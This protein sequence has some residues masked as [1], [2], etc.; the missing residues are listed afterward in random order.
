L[1]ERLDPLPT[2]VEADPD[3]E[4][5]LPSAWRTYRRALETTP[6]WATHRLV[7]QDD[8]AP[9][10]SFPAVLELAVAAR[11]DRI[12]VLCVC[13]R[14]QEMARQL[15]RASGRGD[16]WALLTGLR[17]LPTIAVVWPV[18]LI[19]PALAFVDAQGWPPRFTADDE[20]LGR[21]VRG[22]RQTPLAT[23]PSLVDHRADVESLIRRR[24]PDD[25]GRATACL[26]DPGCDLLAVDWTLGPR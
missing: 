10:P 24:R 26:P 15:F 7:L 12:L 1:L 16:P 4:S 5:P 20:I 18:E 23:V 3:P 14:P 19:G 22:L 13:G 2:S 11:P 8:A 6:G 25:L 21:V 9:C 17:W